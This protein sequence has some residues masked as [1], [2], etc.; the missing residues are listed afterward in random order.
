MS[1]FVRNCEKRVKLN[2]Y[3][4]KGILF[5]C[6]FYEWPFQPLLC[7]PPV[8]VDI[9]FLLLASGVQRPALHLVSAHLRKKYNSYHYQIWHAGLLG[10]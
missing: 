10:K 2:L 7:P 6:V 4:L 1:N 8:G 5:N 3:I 9:L